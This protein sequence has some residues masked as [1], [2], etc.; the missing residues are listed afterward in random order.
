MSIHGIL[1]RRGCGY[2]EKETRGDFDQV[3]MAKSW[4][5]MWVATRDI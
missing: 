4:S 3:R 2:E 5:M 1:A